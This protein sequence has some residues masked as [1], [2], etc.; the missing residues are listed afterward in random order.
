MARR[1]SSWSCCYIQKNARPYHFAVPLRQSGPVTVLERTGANAIPKSVISLVIMCLP[2]C[3]SMRMSMKWVSTAVLTST[4]LEVD[5][6]QLNQFLRRVQTHFDIASDTSGQS[7]GL[8]SSG[9]MNHI[10]TGILAAIK[11]SEFVQN[12]SLLCWLQK[13]RLTL[14]EPLQATTR[15]LSLW[16]WWRSIVCTF[17]T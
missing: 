3:L 2:V 8:Y 5:F 17:S 4:M 9:A 14:L 13:L 16:R 10:S 1:L 15:I 11:S 6:S 12:S 7:G